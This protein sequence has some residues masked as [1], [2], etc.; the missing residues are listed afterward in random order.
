MQD[1][2]HRSCASQGDGLLLPVPPAVQLLT[3]RDR[4]M[5]TVNDLSI[6]STFFDP[7]TYTPRN[8]NPTRLTEY[9]DNSLTRLALLTE[10]FGAIGYVPDFQLLRYAG[11]EAVNAVFSAGKPSDRQIWFVAHHDYR[12]G[13]GAEDN[14][15]A[16]AVMVELANFFRGTEFEAHLRFGSFDL[17]EF[18]CIGSYDYVDK[19]PP[20][21]LAKIAVVFDLECLGSGKH[22]GIAKSVGPRKQFRSD[23]LLVKAITSAAASL[24]YKNFVADHFDFFLADH[25]P[26]AEK[27]IPTVS[28]YSLDHDAYRRH[29]GEMTNDRINCYGSVA[30][31][32][33]D[34]PA[35]IKPENLEHVF[36]VLTKVI[37]DPLYARALASRRLGGIFG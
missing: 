10:M 33:Q 34:I 16:L 26:F 29:R 2:S 14:G 1:F 6:V 19:L 20:E 23:K 21:E 22:I 17:E 32:D 8:L 4:M 24:N 30:H 35:R 13:L 3:P 11:E 18:V 31:S 9:V 28:L 5:A 12:A 7:I 27:K 36:N 37:S 15:T 25:V